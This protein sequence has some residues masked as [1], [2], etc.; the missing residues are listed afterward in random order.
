MVYSSLQTVSI[1]HSGNQGGVTPCCL[2]LAVGAAKS[3]LRS[4]VLPQTSCLA[5]HCFS[6]WARCKGK[7]SGMTQGIGFLWITIETQAVWNYNG[8]DCQ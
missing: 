7:D 6:S 8:K 2:F 1:L 4:A 3:S 5:V